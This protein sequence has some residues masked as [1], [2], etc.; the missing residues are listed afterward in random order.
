MTKVADD[1]SRLLQAQ[2][3]PNLNSPVW[4]VRASILLGVYVLSGK[5][6]LNLAAVNP[7]ASAVWPPTGIALVALVLFDIGLWPSVFLGAFMVNISTTGGILS[8]L[9]IAAGNTI[10]AIL[11]ALLVNQFANGARAI[12]RAQDLIKLALLTGLV[13]APVSATVGVTTLG[14]TGNAAWRD[15][16]RIWTTWWLGDSVGAWLFAPFLLSW[17]FKGGA[18]WTARRAGE[19]ALLLAALVLVT[20]FV[21]GGLGF[22]GGTRLPFEFLCIPVLLWAAFRLG[23]RETTTAAF[24][25]SVVALRGTLHDIGPFSHMARNDA[26][27]SLQTFMGV[28]SIT[29]A[30]VAALV[31]DQRRGEE[32]VQAFNRELELRVK[33]RTEEL[34]RSEDRLVEAQRVAHIGSWEWDMKTDQLWWS[35]ELRRIF[36]LDE[37][38]SVSSYAAFLDRVHPED[39]PLVEGA[40]NRALADVQPFNVEHR[41]IRSDGAVR[42]LD[43]HGYVVVDSA[44]RVVLMTGTGQDVTEWRRLEAERAELFR[45]Q[46]ARR[47]AEQANRLKDAF[48]ATLSHELRTPLNAI[49]GW[50]QILRTRELEAATRRAIGVLDRNATALRHLIEDMLDVSAILSG[51]LHMRREVVDLGSIVEG[52]VD[53]L[54]PGALAKR[55]AIAYTPSRTPPVVDGDS[56]RLTQVVTNLLSNALKFTGADGRIEVDLQVAET[57]AV[58][59]VRDTGIGISQEALPFIF[60]AFRQADPSLT[61]VHGGLGLGLAIV[62]EVVELHGG[63]AHAENSQDQPGAIFTVRLPLASRPVE[64]RQPGPDTQADVRPLLEGLRVL[65]VDDDEDSRDVLSALFTSAGAHYVGVGSAQDGL[66]ACESLRPDLLLVDLAMPGQDGYAFVARAREIGIRAPAIAI[67][68]YADQVHRLQAF[69]AGF[70][71]HLPKPL[72]FDELLRTVAMVVGRSL[73]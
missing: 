11:G 50:L 29:M 22:A 67:T 70:D 21:F 19:A 37:S 55:I 27:V 51:K 46:A 2:L 4:W 49:V 61:R 34:A 15:Y 18:R 25:L 56:Q 58:L 10:E 36:G 69:A 16:D 23:P 9:G 38:N 33:E 73:V 72:A 24:L 59:R 41:I 7:S 13:S 39:R 65:V 62:R 71:A 44:G 48:L 66:E 68:A 31:Q 42:V 52:V 12:E 45:E 64:Q 17:A 35:E 47:E 30:A 28:V 6:G 8:S 57:S 40:N 26:L 53:S 5:F 20:E 3:R 32:R 14:L 43:G 60:D 54:R 1:V 63:V